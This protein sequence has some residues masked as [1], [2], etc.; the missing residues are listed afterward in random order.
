M[1]GLTL[2]AGE[3]AGDEAVAHV[4]IG[5][6]GDF[7]GPLFIAIPPVELEWKMRRRLYDSSNPDVGDA[8]DRMIA[9]AARSQRPRASSSS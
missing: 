3:L 4:G 9:V 8:Y 5:Q 1:Q 2:A 7:P 6:P